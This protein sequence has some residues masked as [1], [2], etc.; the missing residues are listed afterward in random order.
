MRNEA[1]SGSLALRLTGSPRP[2]SCHGLLRPRGLG[3]LLNGQLQG[4]LLSGYEISQAYPGTPE[5]LQFM[6]FGLGGL[7]GVL[8]F[9][10]TPLA[11]DPVMSGLLGQVRLLAK[12]RPAHMRQTIEV[13][14][15]RT[16]H[17]EFPE[18]WSRHRFELGA[19]QLRI[20]HV[21]GIGSVGLRQLPP[22]EFENPVLVVVAQLLEIPERHKVKLMPRQL[23]R[24][25]PENF[26]K[27]P[28]PVFL[29]YSKRLSLL[30][31]LGLLLRR[32]TDRARSVRLALPVGANVELSA[33]C[34]P[35]TMIAAVV[36]G[37]V[38][39]KVCKGIRK[40]RRLK[41]PEVI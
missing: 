29:L 31:P 20:I 22:E 35:S 33:A 15:K 39:H 41:T 6:V 12:R 10:E 17:G 7:A 3:Y 26:L 38:R 28:S 11:I 36:V 9:V 19:G 37:V 25:A 40:E 16:E 8:Q 24:H 2:A 32:Q 1:E 34:L 23:L 14:S 18:R 5:R 4:K 30:L 21:T 13:G 27:Q